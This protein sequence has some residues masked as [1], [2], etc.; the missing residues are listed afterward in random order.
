M[1]SFK[2][3]LEMMGWERTKAVWTVPKRLVG[4]ASESLP[5]DLCV[6]ILFLLLSSLLTAL[7]C[8][9]WRKWARE[10]IREFLVWREC[11]RTG[12]DRWE[13]DPRF[14]DGRDSLPLWTLSYWQVI[15]NAVQARSLSNGC[16]DWLTMESGAVEATQLMHRA[17]R[18]LRV[19]HWEIRPALALSIPSTLFHCP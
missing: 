11:I 16:E 8:R 3:R 6:D 17:R 10:D 4:M 15:L 5:G 14:N 9:R 2:N 18:P 19:L 12:L 1:V 13:E 7:R